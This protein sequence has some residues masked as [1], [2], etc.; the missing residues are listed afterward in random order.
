LV[1]LKEYITMH[2][3]LSVKNLK[4]FFFSRVLKASCKGY[5]R[6]TNG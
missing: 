5:V 2:G 4:Y 6:T 1:L 3:P